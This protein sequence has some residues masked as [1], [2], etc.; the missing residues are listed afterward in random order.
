MR[1]HLLAAHCFWVTGNLS[2]AIHLPWRPYRS[3]P[4]FPVS[5]LTLEAFPCG[6]DELVPKEARTQTSALPHSDRLHGTMALV[7]CGPIWCMALQ[8]AAA[9]TADLC[10]CS[11]GISV[12]R[13][14]LYLLHQQ[15]HPFCF[16][17]LLLWVRQTRNKQGAQLERICLVQTVQDR[18][19]AR[20]PTVNAA[21][22]LRGLPNYQHSLVISVLTTTTS[23]CC[24]LHPRMHRPML[25]SCRYTT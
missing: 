15:W 6:T 25:A 1:L 17:T 20:Y 8:Q 23:T 14:K 16:A 5:R 10:L 13:K 21:V 24:K 18:V 12:V 9:V 3:T 7:S 11:I 19:S 2:H 22:C 4:R